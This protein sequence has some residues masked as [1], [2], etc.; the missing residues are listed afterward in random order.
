MS[1]EGNIENI[2]SGSNKQ[3]DSTPQQTKDLKNTIRSLEKE[4]DSIQSLCPHKEYE[5]RN[6]QNESRGFSLRRVCKSC[7]KEIGYPTQEEIDSWTA[8]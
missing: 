6:C 8:S 5:I 2:G 4:L 1:V 3:G 7:E